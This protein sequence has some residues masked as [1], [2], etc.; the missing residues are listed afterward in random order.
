LGYAEGAESMRM[1]QLDDG[2]PYPLGATWDGRGVNFALFSAHAS[3]VELCLF[4][5]N[6]R[7]ETERFRLP[8]RT[9]QVWHGY[10]KG[11]KPGQLYGYRVHGPYAPERGHRFNP[12]KL[13]IDPYARRLHGR[14]SWH[15][16]LFG[17]RL[18]ARRGD[19]T[20][21][22][23][24]N[25]PMMPKCI[26]DDPA[27]T[28]GDDRP[29][30]RS[31]SST[32]IYEAHVK[33]L[34]YL[35]QGVPLAM[36]GT[37][38]ALGHPAILEHLVKLGVTA[39]ELMP[40][41]AICDDRLLREK[42]LRN[43]WGYSTLAFFAPEPR[44]LGED[45][46]AGFKVAIRSLHDAGIE[47]FLDVAYNHTAEG[48]QLG[49][50]LSFRGI[51]NVSYYKLEPNDP[52]FNW[53]CTGTGNTLNVSH[54]RVLQ[55][56]LD[57]LRYWVEHF[58]IDGFRFD[59]APALAREPYDVNERAGFLRAIGQDPVLARVKLIAEPWDLGEGGYR[60]GG[61]PPGWSEWNDRFRDTLRSYWRGDSGK[62]PTLAQ[63]I[64]GSGEIFEASGRQA[65][66]SVH[67][68]C[69]H[70]GFTLHDLV[71]YNEKH[72]E[73]N[74]HDNSDGHP[75]NFSWNCGVEGETDDR[76]IA[77]LRAQQKRNLL[78]SLFLSI[79]TPMLLM[80]D[81]LSRSQKG[82]NNAYCQDNET[83]WMD[84]EEGSRHDP[85]LLSFVQTL[86]GLRKK[87][88]VFGRRNFLS[89]KILQNELKDVYWLAPEGREMT[90]ADWTDATRRALGVQIGNDSPNGWRFLVLFNAAPESIPFAL[91][92]DFPSRYWIEVFKT[93]LPEGLVREAPAVL[94]PGG[95]FELKA[96]SLVLLQHAKEPR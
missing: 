52:R 66:A 76:E 82:N 36:R 31:W 33:G 23:R 47:V 94:K 73:A 86:A 59:L 37:Y 29:P 39:V 7:H 54:P 16:A 17:Y 58:H 11:V 83:S 25:A 28:W 78:A 9:D 20:I 80:G 40:I 12:N 6:G 60:L 48:N 88:K 38:T 53:D 34:T 27:Y 74:G 14:I 24:D 49:P 71:S 95:S 69:S 32:V 57:S 42:G 79:G 51:D 61:F 68:I 62:L 15:D 43:Y 81:E 72:N 77:A 90:T 56:V 19:L 96:R 3:A 18:G 92:P 63:V 70:D 85:H 35:H 41:N 75:Y 64:T 45:G 89:G 8:Q 5:N 50:T 87:Y 26:V 1:I 55:M 65:W 93:N 10:L 30:R 67:C 2:T 4:K 44:Y 84:W 91:S 22:R 13:L 46:I 21:D